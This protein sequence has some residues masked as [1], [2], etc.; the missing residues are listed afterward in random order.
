MAL[1]YKTID[2][3]LE[4]IILGGFWVTVAAAGGGVLLLA[5]YW[6]SIPPAGMTESMKH[7]LHAVKPVLTIIAAFI[8]ALIAALHGIR[9]QIDFR[10]A[11][12]RAESTM[13][14]LEKVAQNVKR[15][16]DKGASPG[17]KQAVSFVREANEAMSADVAGW[18][19]V[20]RGK[21]PEI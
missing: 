8:P 2:R 6:F 15:A 14:E 10:G 3:R 7:H 11:A 5:A 18:S 19:N 16:L 20:Y 21:G 4:E 9:F 13:R 12:A 1:R 17:R